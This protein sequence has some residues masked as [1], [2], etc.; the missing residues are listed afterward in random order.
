[1]NAAYVKENNNS[2]DIDSSVDYVRK[3]IYSVV[4]RGLDIFCSLFALILLSPLLLITAIAIFIDD[5]G[6][7]LF[8]QT[9]I[10]KDCKPFQILKFRSMRTDAE[11]LKAALMNQ[12]KGANFKIDHD[13]RI[14]RV[15]RFIRATSI[16]ELPQLINILKGD[17]AVIGPRPFIEEEQKNLPSDRLA[18]KPGLSCYWQIGGKNS[19]TLSE[20]IELDRKYVRERSVIVDVKIIIKTMIVVVVG[21]N[22]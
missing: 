10:G 15:G 13:P 1:M 7:V 4:K 19:L 20:Q 3:P 5:P 12:D 18:V 6:P 2:V 14:T 8:K 11:Q 22:G 9:R 16:D 21:K 17:M